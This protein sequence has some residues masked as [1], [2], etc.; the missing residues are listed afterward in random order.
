M[1]S[2]LAAPNE[3]V[4]IFAVVREAIA[5][6][7]A[8]SH[9]G[10]DQRSISFKLDLQGAA[11]I[12]ADRIEILGALVSLI[13]FMRN[14]VPDGSVINLGAKRDADLQ[15]ITLIITL[16]DEC[17]PIYGPA[18]NGTHTPSPGFEPIQLD[19]VGDLFDCVPGPNS[20]VTLRLPLSTVSNR[21][22]ANAAFETRSWL[23]ILLVDDDEAALNINSRLLQ[24]DGHRITTARDG[25][26]G[27]HRLVSES[28]DLVLTDDVMPKM[29]GRKLARA[30][31]K[32]RSDIP[33]IIATSHWSQRSSGSEIP[34]GVDLIIFKPLTPEELRNAVRSVASTRA[35]EPTS[36]RKNLTIPL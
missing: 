17:G 20:G 22:N 32:L 34:E 21:E 14:S 19:A 35:F 8:R 18:Q 1:T 28:Y 29:S 9:L 10:R 26:E 30:V 13:D 11:E 23:K 12:R 24:R 16:R 7:T 6:S 36:Y 33:V 4:D 15:M 31:K 25:I 27:L 2:S 3:D 5:I